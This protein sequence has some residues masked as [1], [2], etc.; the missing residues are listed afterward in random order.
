M[1]DEKGKYGVIRVDEETYAV[2]SE[3]KAY[4]N[5]PYGKLIK[6]AVPLLCKKYRYKRPEKVDENG[7]N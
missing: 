6:V 5:V 3:L 2:L 1:A 7:D 4:T